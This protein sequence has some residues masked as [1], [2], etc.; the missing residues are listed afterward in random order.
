MGPSCPS[1]ALARYFFPP[2]HSPLDR[3][4]N[5]LPLYLQPTVPLLLLPIHPIQS[6]HRRQHSRKRT[7]INRLLNL[8]FHLLRETRFRCPPSPPPPRPLTMTFF[9]FPAKLVEDLTS[10]PKRPP[11]LPPSRLPAAYL[12]LSRHH[13]QSIPYL[14][15]KKKYNCDSFTSL[16]IIVKNSI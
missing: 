5:L 8:M 16:K 7:K 6:G 1:V 3:D 4:Y 2:H 12:F 15:G 14:Q 13:C 11:P 10:F 9:F